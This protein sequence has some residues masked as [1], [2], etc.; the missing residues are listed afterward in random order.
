MTTKMIEVSEA[1]YNSFVLSIARPNPNGSPRVVADVPYVRQ[2]GPTQ[3][4]EYR[5]DGRVIAR[6]TSTIRDEAFYIIAP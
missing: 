5:A 4:A 2:D 6:H 1:K 3:I